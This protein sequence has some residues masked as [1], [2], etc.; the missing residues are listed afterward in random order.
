METPVLE[1]MDTSSRVT[2]LQL[3]LLETWCLVPVACSVSPAL[4]IN[5]A[6]LSYL[7]MLFILCT[8]STMLQAGRSLVQVPDEVDFFS[9]YLIHPAHYGPGVNTASDRNEYQDSSW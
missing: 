3:E 8:S 4:S 5:F 6:L 9:L 7:V 1:I 2:I